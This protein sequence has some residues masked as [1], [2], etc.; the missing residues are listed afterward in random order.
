[1][2]EQQ[3]TTLA[4]IGCHSGVVLQL[5]LNREELIL[6]GKLSHP[7]LVKL[8]GYCWEV[9]VF[10][11]VYEYIQ[12]GSLEK[13][14]FNK[15]AQP[16]LMYTRIK[17]ATGAAQSLAFLLS[18]EN[19][20]ICRDMKSSNILL[21]ETMQKSDIPKSVN[22]TFWLKLMLK[23]RGQI[24]IPIKEQSS[25]GQIEKLSKFHNSYIVSLLGYCKE[26]SN[27]EMIIVY[28]YMSMEVFMIIFTKIEPK[29]G[30]DI[31][32]L[33]LYVNDIFLTTSS[34]SLLRVHMVN[35]NPSQT[36]I[37]TESKL[38]SDGDL[39]CLYMHDPREPHLPA[40][41]RIL[42][43]V[44][45]TFNYGLQLFSSSTSDLV[46]YSVADWAGC[47]TTRRSTLGYCVFLA[48]TYSLGPLSVN[49]QFL[50]LMQRQ[51][52][53]HHR[54]KQVEIDIHFVHDLVD[55]GQVRALHVPSRYQF[56]DIFTKGLPSALFEEFRSSLSV[57]CPPAPTTR[58]C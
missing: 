41:K 6:L 7:D 26:S 40:L 44:R 39:V 55:A 30:T 2:M 33:L 28:E 52:I 45:G 14:V 11:L 10:C 32:Y 21:D 49:R 57:R 4:E 27:R 46:A 19:N 35:C 15:G 47:P 53:V 29:E 25:F 37:A 20:V 51:S 43:Y 16:L 38:G 3:A 48:T 18:S 13:H 24:W 17:I 9:Y 22:M 34:E 54:I 56:A 5:F 23:S 1:M 31:A 58:E 12:K 50:D 42:R 8:F 36:P